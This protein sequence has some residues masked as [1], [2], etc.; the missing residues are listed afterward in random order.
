[1]LLRM[2]KRILCLTKG[3]QQI[4]VIEASLNRKG[5]QM[6]NAATLP[7]S[8][9][10]EEKTAEQLHRLLK[11]KKFKTKRVRAALLSDGIKYQRIVIPFMRKRELMTAVKQAAA[12]DQGQPVHKLYIDHKVIRVFVDKGVKRY[13]V[14]V[15]SCLQSEIDAFEELLRKAK[16]KPVLISTLSGNFAYEPH[17]KKK[18]TDASVREVNAYVYFA[19]G[20][21]SISFMEDD[22]IVFFREFA[23]PVVGQACNPEEDFFGF[24]EE[25]NEKPSEEKPVQNR[26]AEVDLAGEDLSRTSTEIS[27]S[28]RYF[29]QNF[30]EHRVTQLILCGRPVDMATLEESLQNEKIPLHSYAQLAVASFPKIPRE[31]AAQK[32]LYFASELGLLLGAPLREKINFIP[33]LTPVYRFRGVLGSVALL[34]G[35]IL[36]LFYFYLGNE[37]STL[38]QQI[39]I[40]ETNKVQTIARMK[41][42]QQAEAKRKKYNKL[43]PLVTRQAFAPYRLSYVPFKKLSLM[44][45]DQVVLNKIEARR[46]D[47]NWMGS[48]SGEVTGREIERVRYYYESFREVLESS[49]LFQ[50]PQTPVPR[51]GKQPDQE[52]LSLGFH[53]DFQLPVVAFEHRWD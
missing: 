17:F 45:P 35:C 1:M 12:K 49:P 8:E 25:K 50:N 18:K 15:A 2:E 42:L 46:Q 37:I 39:G 21:T 6:Y 33:G 53:A 27:R 30:R 44:I 51:I 10:P 41:K 29:Q 22:Q 26:D 5:A 19:E 52:K 20:Y 43:K 28:L 31:E 16:L 47:K 9:Q 7:L 14:L 3:K 36:G 32:I 13:E 34:T 40:V 11:E 23:I 24:L 48:I 38:Q 4:Q